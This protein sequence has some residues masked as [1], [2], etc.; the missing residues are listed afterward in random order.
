MNLL[1]A[2]TIIG[3]AGCLTITVACY[4]TKS[5]FPLW[6]LILVGLMI[7]SVN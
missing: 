7:E 3:V 4:V 2:K 1:M 6:G 5:A